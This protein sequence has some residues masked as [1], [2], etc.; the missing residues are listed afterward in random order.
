M[1]Y[2]LHNELLCQ[3]CKGETI[4]ELKDLDTFFCPKDILKFFLYHQVHFLWNNEFTYPSS[5]GK[6]IT[7]LTIYTKDPKFKLYWNI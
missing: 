4:N 3:P 5:L 1:N 2:C 6:P 7:I